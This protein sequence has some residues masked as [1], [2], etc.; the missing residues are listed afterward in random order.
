MAIIDC[1]C[2]RGLLLGV[3]AVA[4][5]VAAGCAG[6][7]NSPHPVKGTV[8]LDGQPAKELAGGTV[9]FNSTELHKSASGE[10]QADGTYR[11]G[12]L[13]QNDGAIPGTYQ[14]TVSPP[15][16]TAAG[17]RGDGR[18][19]APNPV[20]FEGPEDQEVTVEPRANDIPIH[21][22]RRGPARR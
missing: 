15:E 12:S 5:F 18:R 11:L 20:R 10:I 17:E 22:R 8:Y 7:V 13:K 21:L 19:A 9:T 16:T 14:V 1:R 4:A 6:G 3:T 2:R